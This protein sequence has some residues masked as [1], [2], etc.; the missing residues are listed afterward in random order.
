MNQS[1][2]HQITIFPS[3][4]HVLQ[5]LRKGEMILVATRSFFPQELEWWPLDHYKG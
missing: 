2:G 4:T 3:P 1:N 5:V